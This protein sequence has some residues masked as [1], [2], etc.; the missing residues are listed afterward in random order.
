[1]RIKND[2]MRIKYEQKFHPIGQ[3]LFYSS[4]LQL[5]EISANVIF[6]CGSENI[7]LINNE[8]TK[9]RDRRNLIIL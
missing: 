6:D 9:R 4:S 7:E 3:G 8:I 5:D 2:V 1:M